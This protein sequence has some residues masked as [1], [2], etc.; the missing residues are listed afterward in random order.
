VNIFFDVDETILGYDDSLRPHVHEV[1][2]QLGVDGHRVY[3]WS[4]ART[5]AGVAEVV[6]RHGLGDFV[7]DCFHK[8][9]VD[10]H[11]AWVATGFD[12]HPDFVIDD[13]PGIVEAFGGM[14][15]RSY[16]LDAPSD[17]EMRRVY[18]VITAA[19]NGSS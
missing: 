16:P 4:G 9:I 3:V 11:A 19:A 17:T 6:A 18:D 13:Y 8:P 2:R 10:P 14:L 15:I 1:F 7:T 5:A 12:V